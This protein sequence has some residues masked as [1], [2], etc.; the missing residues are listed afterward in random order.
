MPTKQ[1]ET[2]FVPMDERISSFIMSQ[3]NL[4]IAVSEN[5]VPYC[6]NCF[7]AY[8]EKQNVFILKSKEETNHIRVALK[9]N[10]VAGTIIPD[11]LDKARI[12]G[13]QFRGIFSKPVDEFL[14]HAKKVYYAKFPF[15]KFV[16]G[17]I[18][19][20]EVCAIKYTDNKLGFRKR[21]NWKKFELSD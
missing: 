2:K 10:N 21:L 19:T 1:P 8:L 20:I 17:D 5:D 15:A 12:Q 18:W 3:T 7:Y 6:A 9:N 13:I 11:S 4:T 16:T 14:H